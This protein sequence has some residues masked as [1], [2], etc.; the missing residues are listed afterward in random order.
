[1]FRPKTAENACVDFVPRKFIAGYRWVIAISVIKSTVI[2]SDYC[3][4]SGCSSGSDCSADSDYCADSGCSS[5]SDYYADS[6]CCP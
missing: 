2:G 5:G 4:D 6:G 1:M 3:A